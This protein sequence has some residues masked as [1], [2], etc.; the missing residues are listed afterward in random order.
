MQ[1]VLQQQLG[2]VTATPEQFIEP[3]AVLFLGNKPFRIDILNSI[4]GVLFETAWNRRIK[5]NIGGRKLAIIHRTD[6]LRNKRASGRPKDLLDVM[7]LRKL[8]SVRTN[9]KQMSKAV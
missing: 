4:S 9:K 1:N 6:L 7:Q 5:A 3:Y 8:S 2:F